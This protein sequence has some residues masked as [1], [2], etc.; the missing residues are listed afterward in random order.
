[1]RGKTHDT[2]MSRYGT[3]E[4]TGA[5]VDALNANADVQQMADAD[6]TFQQIVTDGPDGDLRYWLSFANGAVSAGT[7]DADSPDVTFTQDYATASELS[8]C[9]IK[10]QAAFMQG[11]MT[12]KGNMGKLITHQDALA[13]LG[14]VMSTLAT[15]Y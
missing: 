10:P 4:W 12:I 3:D 9:E 15:D 8:R 2:A 13:L 14:P 5:L 1:M 7:G 6:V 11:R